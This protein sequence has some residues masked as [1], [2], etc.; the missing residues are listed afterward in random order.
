MI[1]SI[2]IFFTM[3]FNTTILITKD[4]IVSIHIE[5]KGITIL[6]IMSLR[7]LALSIMTISTMVLSK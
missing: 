5:A 2:I 1:P 4:L 6:S 7:I 3:T